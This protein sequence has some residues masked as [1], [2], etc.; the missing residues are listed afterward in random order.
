VKKG[1]KDTA[2]SLVEAF[3]GVEYTFA[4]LL[5]LVWARMVL[6]VIDQAI[7]HRH[8]LKC[9]RRHRFV[10]PLLSHLARLMVCCAAMASVALLAA[11]QTPQPATKQFSADSPVPD[12][13]RLMQEV[14][15]HQRQLDKIRESYTYTS[16]ET[17]Q[18]I[19]ANGRVK[20]TETKES[21]VFFVNGHIIGRTVKKNGQPL[22]DHDQQKETERV[23]KLVE[24]AEKTP[25]E[26][27]PVSVSRV[28]EIMDV[29]NERRVNFRGRATI[30][31]DFVGRK[32][33]KTHG[34][35]EDASK[36][37]Q[38]TIWIDEADRQ[39]AHL[40]VTFI[41]NFH[42]AGGLF[43]NIEKGSNFHFDQELVNGELWLPTG[44]DGM[45]QARLLLLKNIRRHSI[46]RDYGYKRFSVE[47][48]QKDA[49][50]PP[51]KKR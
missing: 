48:Q 26:Q 44:L 15:E 19:D 27:P 22:S 37:L 8:A 20:K 46:E 28:L 36:K 24:K 3:G 40:E 51:A 43:I 34:L 1:L 4:L 7:Q 23:T 5:L 10:Y 41:D 6:I 45:M 16:M 49:E 29:R 39:V 18:D 32:D 12:I 50:I 9:A 13:R 17:G 30:V 42:V 38:G 14:Q 25:P 21:E 31:F 11:P 33:A 47:T 2:L 35:V